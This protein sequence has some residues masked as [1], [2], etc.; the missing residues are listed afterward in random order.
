MLTDAPETACGAAICHEMDEIYRP[1]GFWGS[2]LRDAELNYTVTE[3]EA[4]AVVKALKN[5]EDML[6][7]AKVT[8]IT[9]HKP[10]LPL[11]Q[12]AYKAPSARLRR[13]ALAITDFDFD[14]RY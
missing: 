4:L 12:A 2:T 10:L 7:G 5:Y 1:I 3:K 11:L 8:V 6:Q 13:W 14:I 9:D